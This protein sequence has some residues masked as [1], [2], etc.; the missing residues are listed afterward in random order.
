MPVTCDWYDKAQTILYCRLIGQ[1]TAEEH[2]A[3][4]AAVY[5][6]V[7][8]IPVSTRFDIIIDLTESSYTPPSGTLWTWKQNLEM[9]DALFP[10]Y[11]LSVFINISRVIDAYLEEG[12][13][14]SAAIRQ[15]T[16]IVSTLLEA[17][18]II[19]A[20]RASSS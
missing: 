7:Q 20:D 8:D 1:W 9:R 11:G 6:L 12:L 4:L 5:Q 18:K 3:G 19:Q 16:R 13:Q 10:N 2:K 14:T 15:H 17:I